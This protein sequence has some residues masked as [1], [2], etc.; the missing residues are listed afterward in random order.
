MIEGFEN[1]LSDWL[2]AMARVVVGVSLCLYVCSLDV[3]NI[4]GTQALSTSTAWP[5]PST[6]NYSPKLNSI[7]Y[8]LL[9]PCLLEG[10]LF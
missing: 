8:L 6:H 5:L 2:S 9:V 3:W 7:M 10:L 4:Y 1:I